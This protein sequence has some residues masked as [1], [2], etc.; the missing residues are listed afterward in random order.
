M[1]MKWT[2]DND[3]DN[4]T[5]S[6]KTL[7]RYD[8]LQIGVCLFTCCQQVVDSWNTFFFFFLSLSY[9]YVISLSKPAGLQHSLFTYLSKLPL[10]R[11]CYYSIYVYWFSSFILYL[12]SVR[13]LFFFYMK[14]IWFFVSMF[15]VHGHLFTKSLPHVFTVIIDYSFRILMFYVDFM[16]II[17][18]LH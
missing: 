6:N 7:V 8:E 14:L 18:R 12:V 2:G 11:E 4:D 17:P 3:N 5:H 1:K 9:A 15:N 10:V 13:K 16:K